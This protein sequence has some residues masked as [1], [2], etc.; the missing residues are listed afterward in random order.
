M[1]DQNLNQFCDYCGTLIHIQTMGEIL[2]PLCGKQFDV[3]L[4]GHFERTV[5]LKEDVEEDLGFSTGSVRTMINERCPECSHEGLYFST[6]QLR[7]A[8]EGQTIFYE[9]PKCGYK[10]QQNA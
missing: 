2:C 6:A 8:D 10:Y 9:C 5:D 1:E 7:S 4:L 3:S